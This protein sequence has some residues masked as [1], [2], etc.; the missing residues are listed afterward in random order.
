VHHGAKRWCIRGHAFDEVNTGIDAQ[1]KRYCKACRREHLKV[2][3][4]TV[5][6]QAD[7]R[8]EFHIDAAAWLA[9]RAQL[10]PRL[11]E[12]QLT[13]TEAAEL[14][15]ISVNAFR[16]WRRRHPGRQ[17]RRR[18]PG[19]LRPLGR[20]RAPRFCQAEVQAMLAFRT[21]EPWSRLKLAR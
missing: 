8:P 15:E 11:T 7:R 14:C 9:N 4:K 20:D 12:P 2:W 13:T 17:W 16:Q 21:T 3:R 10:V 19:L 5:A 6:G 1:G 18:H